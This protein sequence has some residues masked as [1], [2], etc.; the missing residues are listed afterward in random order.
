MDS[1]R[2]RVH[3]SH[4]CLKCGCKYGDDDCPVCNGKIEQKY[5][6]KLCNDDGPDYSVKP[7]EIEFDI[8]KYT[9]GRIINAPGRIINENI[10]ISA[11]IKGFL[12]G[13]FI[14]GIIN[15]IVYKFI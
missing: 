8:P 3:A 11:F 4:C 13:F 5:P 9:P 15:I 12:C 14:T 2:D 6:C 10:F 1:V 7:P